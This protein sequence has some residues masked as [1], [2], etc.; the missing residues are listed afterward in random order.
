M[1]PTTPGPPPVA[2]L[3]NRIDDNQITN[4]DSFMTSLKDELDVRDNLLT[5]KIQSISSGVQTKMDELTS[6]METFHH[7]SSV[8]RERDDNVITRE[9]I[10]SSLEMSLVTC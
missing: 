9:M 3:I 5:D 4:K 7:E 6:L 1:I 2:P 10:M 8:D